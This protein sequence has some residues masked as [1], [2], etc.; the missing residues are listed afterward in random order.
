VVKA[1]V[2]SIHDIMTIKE[3]TC[4]HE[5]VYITEAVT[6]FSHGFHMNQYGIN[7]DLM[8][9]IHFPLIII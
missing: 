4:E 6:F 1:L 2:P 7:I 8:N 3:G 5:E 9:I